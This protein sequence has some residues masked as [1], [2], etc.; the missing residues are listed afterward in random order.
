M[1]SQDAQE[2]GLAVKDLAKVSTA[3]GSIILP[4]K[5][6]D[7]LQRKTVAVPHMDGG[8]RALPWSPQ[9]RHQV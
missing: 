1:H 8:I 5:Y 9:K 6:L 2:M 3:T 7:D 4:V